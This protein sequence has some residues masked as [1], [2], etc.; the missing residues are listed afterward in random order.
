M[1]SVNYNSATTRAICGCGITTLYLLQT[2][3]VEMTWVINDHVASGPGQLS[4]TKGQQVEV[5]EVVQGQ[6]DWRLVK[7][8]SSGLDPPPEG[9]V[10]ASVLKQPPAPASATLPTAAPRIHELDPGTSEGANLTTNSPVNKRRVFSTKWLPQPLRKL[11]G[12]KVEKASPPDRPLL[13]KTPSDKRLKN[14]VPE[15][16]KIGTEGSEE[17]PRTETNGE[18]NEEEVV[19]LPPPMAPISEPILVPNNEPQTLR[20]STLSLE[21]ATSA[22]LAEIE[23]IVKERM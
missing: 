19:E 1:S 7:M 15:T 18:E 2:G 11:S 16:S 10:P 8:P 6:P 12:A 5:V 3:G 20:T 9:T 21:G 17:A 13:K 22:D 14:P 4:V 23:Q